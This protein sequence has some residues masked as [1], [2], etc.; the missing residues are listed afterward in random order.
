MHVAPRKRYFNSLRTGNVH[1]II[2]LDL[3]TTINIRNE[4]TFLHNFL[5]NLKQWHSDIFNYSITQQYD[6]KLEKIL[7]SNSDAKAS[8]LLE[9]LKELFPR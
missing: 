1:R 9:N 3:L 7:S 4:E 8:E 2:V 5:A 6:N